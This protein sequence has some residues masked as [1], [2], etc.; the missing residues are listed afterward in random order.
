MFSLVAMKR[1]TISVPVSVCARALTCANFQLIACILSLDRITW[2]ARKLAHSLIMIIS[3]VMLAI[4][5]IIRPGPSWAHNS[6]TTRLAGLLRDRAA[7]SAI[8]RGPLV[9]SISARG[10]R[11]AASIIKLEVLKHKTSRSSASGRLAWALRQPA[12]LIVCGQPA[13]QNKSS[14]A[15]LSPCQCQVE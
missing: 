10:E 5:I 3:S 15:T 4:I 8:S 13:G 12:R 11:R 14:A 1:A 2:P 6:Y 9:N 7:A